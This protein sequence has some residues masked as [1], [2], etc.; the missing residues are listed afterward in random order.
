MMGTFGS[1]ISSKS[2]VQS[3][4]LVRTTKKQMPTIRFIAASRCLLLALFGLT[5]YAQSTSFMEDP[6]FFIKYNP[7]KVHFPL[8]P[9]EFERTCATDLRGRKGFWLYAYWKNGN[10][11]YFI[12]NSKQTTLTGAAAVIRGGACE[13]GL[14]EWLLTGKAEYHETIRFAVA[15][16][17]EV[18]RGLANDLFHRYSEAFGGKMSFLEA[19][20]KS[21]ISPDRRET[22]LLADEFEKFAK[23]P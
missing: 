23:Q 7:G 20:R 9:P 6:V 8:A 5:T 2:A 11:E 21:G 16:P 12:L 3:L 18:S 10:A 17:E 22:P 13:L 19:L 4:T 14:P 15:I 1:P